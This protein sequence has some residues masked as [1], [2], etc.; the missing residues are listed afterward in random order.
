MCNKQ[1]L[2][3]KCFSFPKNV[4][5]LFNFLTFTCMF[6]IEKKTRLKQIHMKLINIDI[7]LIF[8]FVI[9]IQSYSK[10]QSFK[11][12]SIACEKILILCTVC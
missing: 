11:F 2:Y 5:R 4:L 10:F 9:E 12:L 8:Q 3:A 6:T 1:N 7:L